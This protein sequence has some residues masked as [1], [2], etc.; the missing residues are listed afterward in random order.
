MM[1]AAALLGPPAPVVSRT[2]LRE[3]AGAAAALPRI[4][5]PTYALE[6]ALALERELGVGHV[7]A[8]VLVRRGLGDPGRAEA[9]LAAEESHDPHAFGGHPARDVEHPLR[10]GRD[11]R[12]EKRAPPRVLPKGEEPGI[13]VVRRA[14]RSEQLARA[15]GSGGGLHGRILA[16]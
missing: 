6:Q 4:D 16:A 8:Q 10:L 3:P 2:P 7:L 12:D 15:P 5:I 9:F 14:E 13:A 1:Q 11:P